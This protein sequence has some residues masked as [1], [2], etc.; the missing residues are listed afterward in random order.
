MRPS[1][2]IGPWASSSRERYN[3]GWRCVKQPPIRVGRLALPDDSELLDELS[4]VRL[5][6]ATPG[7]YR[8]DID[9]SGNDAR[10]AGTQAGGAG[11]DRAR[12]GA[13]LDLGSSLGAASPHSA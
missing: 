10:R 3:V 9:A 8:L 2:V 1:P 6:E 11:A 5:R 7:V 4:T 13:R 12:L